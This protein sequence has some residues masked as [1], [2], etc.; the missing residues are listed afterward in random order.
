MD[1]LNLESNPLRSQWMNVGVKTLPTALPC[2]SYAFVH[3]KH[4]GPCL[5][6]DSTYQLHS[7]YFWW[8]LML[9][10]SH[11]K[12]HNSLQLLWAINSTLYIEKLKKNFQNINTWYAKWTAYKQKSEI[13]SLLTIWVTFMNGHKYCVYI[14][15]TSTAQFTIVLLFWPLMLFASCWST[16]FYLSVTMM[17]ITEFRLY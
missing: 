13:I 6:S 10:T 15:I 11:Y 8:W 17:P 2:R 3:P 16:Y 7:F 12:L 4:N 14:I 1:W 9:L 5:P